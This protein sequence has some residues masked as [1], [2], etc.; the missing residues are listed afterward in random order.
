MDRDN[1]SSFESNILG[2][3]IFNNIKA[4]KDLILFAL[5]FLFLN[6]FINEAF[7]LTLLE[8]AKEA[9]KDIEEITEIMDNGE[10]MAMQE[11]EVI[12]E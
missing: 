8:Q 5:R 2:F 3:H 10:I 9:I 11:K 4:R 6:V 7:P 1:F 12:V